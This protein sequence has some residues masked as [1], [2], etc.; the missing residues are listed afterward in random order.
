M[1]WWHVFNNHSTWRI[2]LPVWPGSVYHSLSP[3]VGFVYER[4]K[5]NTQ[6]S[7]SYGE[8]GASQLRAECKN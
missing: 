3:G 7:G 2:T 6:P 8:G 4:C 5:K 1:W